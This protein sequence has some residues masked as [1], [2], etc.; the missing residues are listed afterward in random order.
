METTVVHCR[1]DEYDVLICRPSKWGNP[2]THLA[3]RT[4]RA[5]HVVASRREAIAKYRAHVL[6]RPDLLAALDELRGK[7]L[8]CWC[9]PKACH[10][11]VLVA[12]LAERDKN[13][14]SLPLPL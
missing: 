2:Y 8:G 4:T 5:E 3:D 14:Y 10:G 13:T 7:R 6:A 1:R 9:F 11:D 12:L